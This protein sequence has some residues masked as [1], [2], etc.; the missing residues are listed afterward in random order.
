MPH[1]GQLDARPTVIEAAC[2]F[3]KMTEIDVEFTL[4]LP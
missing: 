3:R 1:T 2:T 4:R